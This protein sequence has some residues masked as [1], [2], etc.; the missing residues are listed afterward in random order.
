MIEMET[1]PTDP[2]LFSRLVRIARSLGHS[3][4]DAEDIAQECLLALSSGKFRGDASVHTW[5]YRVLW[6]KHV[7]RLRARR[8]APD[9]T[10][11]PPVAFDTPEITELHDRVHDALGELSD[12]HQAI[13]VLRFFE[14][15]AYREI[16][17]I[18]ERAEGTL[19]ADCFRALEE[20][21]DVLD[22]KY[23]SNNVKEWL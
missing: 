15:L 12:L 4:D 11:D 18:L 2:A 20:L 9:A 14:G 17:E 8:P 7:D 3:H 10:P 22:R 6:N 21:H 19:H 1:P 16:A 13:L 5:L 23:G